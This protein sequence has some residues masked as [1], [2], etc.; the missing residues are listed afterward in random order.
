FEETITGGG[1][2]TVV[3]GTLYAGP[4]AAGGRVLMGGGNADDVLALLARN[5]FVVT[6]GG[7]RILEQLTGF[8]GV[9][10]WLERVQPRHYATGGRG[11]GDRA[12]AAIGPGAAGPFSSAINPAVNAVL[13]SYFDAAVKQA[14]V[15]SAT[16]GGG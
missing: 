6:G 15:Q 4:H 3:R 2:R 11:A 12:L 1:K 13:R 9:L 10:D 16:A 7:E 8:P 5:E 14:R